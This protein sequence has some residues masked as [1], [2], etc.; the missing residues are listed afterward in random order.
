MPVIFTQVI[1]QCHPASLAFLFTTGKT[2]SAYR[3]L[4]LNQSPTCQ[5]AFHDMDNLLSTVLLTAM[6]GSADSVAPFALGFIKR[7]IRLIE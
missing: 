2:L 6:P 3:A 7:I 1:W 4:R 5:W